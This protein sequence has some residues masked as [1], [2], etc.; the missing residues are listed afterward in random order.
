MRAGSGVSFVG[1]FDIVKGADLVLRAFRKVLQSRPSARLVFAGPDN[2]LLGADG[3]RV[4]IA[5]FVASLQDPRLASAFHW[6][7]RLPPQEI[8]DLRVKAACVV[9]PS[10]RESQG[11]TALEAMLQGCPRR[12]R[13][14][15]RPEG[16]DRPWRQRPKGQARG[17]RRL[18]SEHHEPSQRP[19]A[20]RA[21]GPGG[22]ALR[23]RIPRSFDRCRAGDAVLSAGDRGGKGPTPKC[24]DRCR[25]PVRP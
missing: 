24:G 13:R 22:A 17:C 7:G 20:G 2:G 16:A 21:S 12:L 15:V 11:Y 5:D 14:R 3:I 6:R 8:A 19:R 9:V 23:S 10:R 4:G 25:Q 18:G 1:R